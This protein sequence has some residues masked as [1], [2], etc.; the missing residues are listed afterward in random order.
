MQH[1]CSPS[2]SNAT[3][4]FTLLNKCNR[5]VHAEQWGSGKELQLDYPSLPGQVAKPE[6]YQNIHWAQYDEELKQNFIY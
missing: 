1:G 4:M 2:K 3:G 6:R 5:D